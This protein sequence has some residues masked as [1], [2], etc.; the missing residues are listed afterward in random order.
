MMEKFNHFVLAQQPVYNRVFAELKA[1]RK[2]SHW[3]W[4]I[5]PQIQGLGR[6]P[7]AQR[8]ALDSI[9]QASDYLEHPLLGPRILNCTQLLLTHSDKTARAMLGTPDDLK[10]K[11][12]MTLS[13]IH[14]SE[15]TRPY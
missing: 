9:Q 5:F 3:M 7:M 11:S 6:S 12:S 1:G 13:L 10:L 2:Q 14:I 4:F 15:P 8:F